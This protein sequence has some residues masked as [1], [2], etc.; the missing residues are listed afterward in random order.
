MCGGGIQPEPTPT[1]LHPTPPNSN[2]H[3]L[4]VL[5]FPAMKP[6]A[7][8]VG[9]ATDGVAGLSVV[10]L[11]Q[12]PSYLPSAGFLPARLGQDQPGAHLAPPTRAAQAHPLPTCR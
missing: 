12:G 9:A 8:A 1:Q 5:L 4:Q 10:S 3:R 2:P 11:L 7:A 6:E